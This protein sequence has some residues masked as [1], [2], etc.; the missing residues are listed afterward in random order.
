MTKE[1]LLI[2]LRN[3]GDVTMDLEA[4]YEDPKAAARKWLI[5]Y[6]EEKRKEEEC[7]KS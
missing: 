1:P 7:Q 3:N 2:T 6:M 4:V 5:Q